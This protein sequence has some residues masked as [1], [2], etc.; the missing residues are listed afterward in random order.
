MGQ[1]WRL[2]IKT[3]SI[4]GIDPR[5][6]CLS[7][8]ILG[9]GWA[10]D[11]EGSVDWDRY[12]ELG[13][14]KY[15]HTGD[16]GW[17]P[18]VN[19]VKNRMEANDLCWTRDWDGV[20]Y[21]GRIIGDWH[22]V[23]DEDHLKADVVNVRECDWK[24]IGTID[25]VPGKVVNSFIPARTV[26]VVDD[27]A[28]NE[29]SKYLYNKHSDLFKYPLAPNDGD[30]FSLLS[31]EDCEDIVGLYLQGLGYRMIPSSCKADTAAYEYVMKH[32][33]NHLTAVAQ[34]KNGCVDLNVDDFKNLSAEVYLFTSRGSYLGN[35]PCN[36]H[37][38]DLETIKDF[39]EEN[40]AL[41]PERVQAWH[42]LSRSLSLGE[43]DQMG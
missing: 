9:V 36:I 33:V 13:K 1:T 29:L 39:M 43:Q 34:V 19:A 7:R 3:G 32:S 41:L 40:F 35:V 14:S 37:C 6:F 26:Q 42:A 30:I 17:W 25:A 15:Y 31:A 38:I 24:K 16:K 28:V 2:N 8:G 18:A 21:L 12:Y 23:G 11:A 22:Y 10:V 5:K 20:Y 27:G 4:D